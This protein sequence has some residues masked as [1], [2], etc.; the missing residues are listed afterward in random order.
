[1]SDYETIPHGLTERQIL[2]MYELHESFGNTPDG[3]YALATSTMAA[4]MNVTNSHF[5]KLFYEDNKGGN[6][7]KVIGTM[8]CPIG[9]TW[10]A[11]ASG[12]KCRAKRKRRKR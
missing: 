11:K 12:R 1:M 3:L 2:A 10:C 7:I 5:V 6:K 9:G 8:R 4:F